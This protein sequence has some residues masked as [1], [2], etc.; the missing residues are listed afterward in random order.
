MSGINKLFPKKIKLDNTKLFRKTIDFITTIVLYVLLLTLIVG[1]AK[2]ILDLKFA[3]FTSLEVG[4]NQMVSNVLTI[5]I[6]IDLFNIF[7]DY[8]EHD[9]IKLTYVADA[10]ILIVMREVA[11]GMYG[12]K[13][14]PAFILSLSALLLVIVIVR[15]LAIKYSPEEIHNPVSPKTH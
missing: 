15:V 8:H 9:R 13:L 2:T 3:V 7:V 4:F 14:E 1:M 6:L 12:S 10:T 5:F 11:V